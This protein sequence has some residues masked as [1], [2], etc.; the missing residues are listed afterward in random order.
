V[1]KRRSRPRE[2]ERSELAERWKANRKAR[3]TPQVLPGY[4]ET[5]ESR[6]ASHPEAHF[7]IAFSLGLTEE[8]FSQLR[9]RCNEPGQ[10]AKE[11]E[12]CML[13]QW[14]YG[15]AVNR[16]FAK[17]LETVRKWERKLCDEYVMEMLKLATMLTN[18]PAYES[19]QKA[20]IRHRLN[21]GGLKRAFLKLLDRHHEPPEYACV[22]STE[23]WPDV[24]TQYM[25][26]RG[27]GL[28]KAVEHAVADLGI[29]GTSFADAV[30]KVRKAYARR[31]QH[32]VERQ[33]Y[34]EELHGIRDVEQSR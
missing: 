32:E 7:Q 8:E 6:L 15:E 26:E 18:D 19:A 25:E 27:Y 34:L 29:P 24:V 28:R 20:M 31:K 10:L 22:S 3:E 21:K 11:I 13:K 23:P 2:T 14:H 9:Q 30:D 4:G 5:L 1:N 17:Q 16:H 12:H 33:R